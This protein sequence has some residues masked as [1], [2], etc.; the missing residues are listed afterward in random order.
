VLAST[1]RFDFLPLD[2]D[3]AK[4]TDKLSGCRPE[5]YA[6]KLTY[7][8]KVELLAFLIDSVHDLDEFRQFLNQRLE[9]KSSYNKQKMDIY[10]EIK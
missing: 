9:E 6:T 1:K 7:D 3:M 5:T 8:D 4:I 10:V 2:D